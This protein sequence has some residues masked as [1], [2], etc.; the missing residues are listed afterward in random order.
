[1]II[2]R[3]DENLPTINKTKHTTKREK[4]VQDGRTQALANEEL[5]KRRWTARGTW[6]Q[7]KDLN[8]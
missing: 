6:E 2:V 5:F 3:N 7:I 8:P 1:M 4:K